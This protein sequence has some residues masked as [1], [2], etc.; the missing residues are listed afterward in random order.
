M[1]IRDIPE[2]FSYLYQNGKRFDL[3]M[4][5]EHIFHS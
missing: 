5:K 2:T 4:L 1:Y 3:H